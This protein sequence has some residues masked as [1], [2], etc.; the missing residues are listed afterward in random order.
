MT[1]QNTTHSPR[2][3]DQLAHETDALT[4]GAPD[5]GR[6]EWRRDQVPVEGE[7]EIFV[8]RDDTDAELE[9][10]SRLAQSLVPSAFPGTGASLADAAA[11]N[12]A[13]PDFV[14][15]LR[16]LPEGRVYA[17]FSEVWQDLGGE[18]EHLDGHANIDH[19]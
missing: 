16:S 4:H 10:R 9:T 18:I 8:E 11:L 12:N 1:D 2:V 3:D 13:S 6:Q 7:P 17:A 19:T 14:D 15:A 5:D